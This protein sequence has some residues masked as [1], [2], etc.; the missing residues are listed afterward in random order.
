MFESRITNNIPTRFRITDRPFNNILNITGVKQKEIT[1][2]PSESVIL[3]VGSGTNQSFSR[4]VKEIRPDI[5][6][7]SLDPTIAIKPDDFVTTVSDWK[8]HLPSALYY[9]N[10]SEN[11]DSEKAYSQRIRDLRIE[12]AIITGNVIAGLAPNLPF[13]DESIDLIIDSW[14]AG[15]YLDK[16]SGL[17][18]EYIKEISRILKPGGKAKIYPVFDIQ[19]FNLDT[20]RFKKLFP[21]LEIEFVPGSVFIGL[22]IF[23]L[24]DENSVSRNS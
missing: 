20:E 14:A 17:L 21:S 7:V 10:Y 8:K 16:N 1:S 5:L 12:Q 22:S 23:K 15:Y 11:S 9:D 24:F 3:E 6:C 19:G 2:L 4:G 18:L 13:R